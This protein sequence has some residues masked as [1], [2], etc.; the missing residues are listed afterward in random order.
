M[1]AATQFELEE[2][3]RFLAGLPEDQGEERRVGKYG[4]RFVES[5]DLSDYDGPVEEARLVNALKELGVEAQTHEEM[6]AFVSQVTQQI[7]NR[8]AKMQ[9]HVRE[10]ESQT[11]VY[12]SSIAASN[13]SIRRF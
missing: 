2:A 6:M 3:K 5:A 7:Q 8:T 4:G 13:A 1:E 10:L 11:A 9:D 12:E